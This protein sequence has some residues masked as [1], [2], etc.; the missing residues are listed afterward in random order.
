[1]ETDPEALRAMELDEFIHMLDA[2]ANIKH[3]LSK[4]SDAQRRALIGACSRLHDALESPEEKVIRVML[5][6]RHALPRR[7]LNS[8][9]SRPMMHRLYG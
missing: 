1:M 6:V 7:I 8:P 9:L 4:L 3:I 5:S 2:T